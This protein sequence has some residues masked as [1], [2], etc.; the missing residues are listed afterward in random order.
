MVADDADG[1]LVAVDEFFDQHRLAIGRDKI[2]DGLD[3]SA[4]FFDKIGRMDSFALAFERRLDD[5]GQRQRFEAV[6]VLVHVAVD[7]EPIGRRH[8]G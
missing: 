5:Y 4:R 6:F 3:E 1:Q 2:G 8:T 7:D